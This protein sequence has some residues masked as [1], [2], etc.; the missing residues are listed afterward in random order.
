MGA[1]AVPSTVSPGAQTQTSS[2]FPCSQAGYSL[3]SAPA[4]SADAE[5][6]AAVL[7]QKGVIP[8]PPATPHGVKLQGHCALSPSASAAA[9]VPHGAALSLWN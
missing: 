5:A 9:G 4:S 2:S 7:Y 6:A 8:L 3:R 1:V